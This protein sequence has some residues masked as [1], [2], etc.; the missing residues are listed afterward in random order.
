[1]ENASKALII[2]GAIL[3]SILI[4][5]LGMMV[6]NQAKNAITGASLDAEKADAI[7]SKYEVYLGSQKGT[8]V[9][10][11]LDLIKNN[12]LTADQSETYTIT[13][14]GVTSAAEINAIKNSVKN[15][16]TYT[17]S[18]TYGTATENGGTIKTVTI[19]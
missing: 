8:N 6:F 13:V 12:N 16:N 4:I 9:K 7:N 10:S 15:G 14:N 2:A 17:V 3:L 11:L 1:M 19:S 18:F 5:G